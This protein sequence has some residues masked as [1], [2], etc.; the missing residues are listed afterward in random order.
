MA[1]RAPTK[2]P[3]RPRSAW[4]SLLDLLALTP[5]GAIPFAL[6]FGILSGATRG[7]FVGAYILS[8]YFGY[9]IGLA[10]WALEH[11]V[12]L[13]RDAEGAK[14]DLRR[15]LFRVGSYG[16]ASLVGAYAAA[17]AIHFTIAPTFLGSLKEVLEIGMFTL[18]FCALFIGITAAYAFYHQAVD[19]AKAEQELHLARRIQRSFLLSQFPASP[20]LEVHA[21]NVSSKEVS[22]DIY[23]V[24]PAGAGAFLLA[25]AD[26]AGKGV[27]AALLS[28][29]LQASLRTQAE[30]TP[31][32]ADILQNINALVYRS[33]AVNQFATFFLARVDEGALRLAYSN[34]G[35]NYPMLFRRGGEVLTLERG[36]T[37]L[38]I[39]ER[40]Q[41]EEGRVALAPGDR[42]VFYTDGINEAENE[43]AE[44]FGDQRLE[45]LVV[46][47]PAGLS[48][49]EITERILDGVRGFLGD[50][51]PGDD[52]TV[53]VLRVLEPEESPAGA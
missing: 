49:R 24:V 50:A 36:G 47:L 40:A 43:R 27:P 53:M 3:K 21:V 5:L 13:P 45:Q 48:A 51:E 34:A 30:S 35:H 10:I 1:G 26:V 29:M 18:L 6:F 32:V 2:R 7:A 42:L 25:I 8:L 44:Q 12:P 23:D 15:T 9:A 46:A 11:F 4:R 16:V 22:G 41:F 31:S 52:M 14:P 28:S 19:K 20:R 33:T 17:F 37:V 38:G 39:I